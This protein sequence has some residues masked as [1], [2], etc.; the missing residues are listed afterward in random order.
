MRV[1]FSYSFHTLIPWYFLL[2]FFFIGKGNL[3]IFIITYYD[4]KAI[5]TILF[6]LTSFIWKR[7]K[8]SDYPPPA[9]SSCVLGSSRLKIKP[10]NQSRSSTGSQDPLLDSP[11]SSVTIPTICA[12]RESKA[13]CHCVTYQTQDVYEVTRKHASYFFPLTYSLRCFIC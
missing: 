9:H 3:Y 4:S 2:C 10:G 7:E 5:H 6:F 12:S 11:P 1:V 8:T 13:Y